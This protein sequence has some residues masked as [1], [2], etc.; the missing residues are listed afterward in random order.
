[1]WWGPTVCLL[2]SE[3]RAFY[4]SLGWKSTWESGG[5]RPGLEHR[6]QLFRGPGR[7]LRGPPPGWSGCWI[8]NARSAPG[9]SPLGDSR[10]QP[11][12]SSYLFPKLSAQE[13]KQMP[14]HQLLPAIKMLF[15]ILLSARLRAERSDTQYHRILKTI[16]QETD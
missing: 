4:T 1:M 9:L 5:I 10:L 3:H 13:G 14:I 6:G 16:L 2:S 15:E 8:Q 11:G 12:N 7:M